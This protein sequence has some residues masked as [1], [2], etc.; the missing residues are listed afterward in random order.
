MCSTSEEREHQVAIRQYIFSDAVRQHLH[1]V[2]TGRVASPYRQHY[3]ET[4]NKKDAIFQLTQ[5]GVGPMLGN[6]T[7]VSY[8]SVSAQ[9]FQLIT[10]V[11]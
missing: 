4:I 11:V 1:D 6:R 5:V 3:L 2:E 8:V 9:T 7:E 10:Y